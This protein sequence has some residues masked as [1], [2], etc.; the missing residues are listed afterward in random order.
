MPE[1]ICNF[2]D[3]RETAKVLTYVLTL[4]GK[5]R[6]GFVRERKRRSDAQNKYLWGVCYP[7]V[8]A[9]LLEAWG[10]ARTDDEVHIF[11]KDKFLSKPLIDRR[12]GEIGGK[13]FPSSRILTVPEFCVYVDSII[14]FAAESLNVAIPAPDEE[15]RKEPPAAVLMLDTAKLGGIME[16]I[17]VRTDARSVRTAAALQEAI[18]RKG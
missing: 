12:T 17:P 14:K 7:Y 8:A 11:L 15:L 6:V 2:D 9:G 10:E 13:T 5:W 3:P 18:G 4:K 16:P 1:R